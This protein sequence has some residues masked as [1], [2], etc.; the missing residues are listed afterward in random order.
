[1]AFRGAL[2]AGNIA[3]G[4]NPGRHPAAQERRRN[5]RSGFRFIPQAHAPT[6]IPAPLKPWGQN[7][8]ATGE[9]DVYEPDGKET[10]IMKKNSRLL[11][12]MAVLLASAMVS[13]GFAAPFQLSLVTPVQIISSDAPVH[14]LALNLIFGLNSEV[15]GG[16]IGLINAV[17][18]NA[19]AF[20]L[21]GINY[22]GS[23]L[24]GL[25][26]GLLNWTGGNI[27]GGQ[28]S[29]INWAGGDVTGGQGGIIN[30][31]GGNAKGIQ[32]GLINYV[33]GD[34]G[35]AQVSLINVAGGLQGW[36]FGAI[37]YALNTTGFQLGLINWTDKLDGLQI[38]A[39]NFATGKESCWKFLPI[40]N[41][42][43]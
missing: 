32:G 4:K 17:S 36:Q 23:D 34:V 37:N 40:V 1:M 35:G 26:Y 21:G 43:W 10:Q 2:G 11:T 22:V 31:I 12:G 27:A 24:T 13:V 20:M 6:V 16:D 18:G 33:G 9:I 29:L 28:E 41:A 19:S 25:Q 7:Q 15:T 39:L 8:P 14:G 5:T 42:G 3:P 30:L 38:G